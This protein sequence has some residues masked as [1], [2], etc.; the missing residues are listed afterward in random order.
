[1]RARIHED[2]QKSINNTQREHILREQLR[3]VRKEL[4]EL[5][6]TSEDSEE[7]LTERVEA[8]AL[9]QDDLALLSD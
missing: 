9:S 7:S 5:D 3:L 1:M 2:V 8:L 6:G 4:S